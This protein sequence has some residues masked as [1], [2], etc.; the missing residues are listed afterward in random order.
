MS[1]NEN[2]GFD[3][4]AEL[5]KSDRVPHAVLIEGKDNKQRK[6]AVDY[7]SSYAVCSSD[8]R[9]CGVC[10]NCQKANGNGHSDIIIPKRQGKTNIINVDSMRELIKEAS[11]IPNEARTKVFIL[12]DVDKC[13]PEISQN[14]FLKVLEE[15]P[16]STLFIL[17]AEKPK[18]LLST[19]LSRVQVFTLEKFE[20]Q[21]D[22]LDSLAQDIIKGIVDNSELR[23]LYATAKINTRELFKGTLPIVSEYLRLSLADSVGNKGECE[24][25]HTISKK[26][27]KQKI[28][29]LIE[30][31]GKAIIKADRNVNMN[32]L[33]T[34]LCGEYRR[35]SWQR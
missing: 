33:C 6:D 25:A 11:I 30:L 24:I 16:Q 13:L 10:S 21:S 18:R 27:T 4:F 26:L 1:Q 3:I 14:T 17:T 19:I 29:A 31:T 32:L 7:L 12:N 8:N 2:K 23:L 28:I 5:V 9:P 22:E 35:I 15:P 34:W 20:E